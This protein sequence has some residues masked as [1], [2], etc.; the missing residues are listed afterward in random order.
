MQND[1]GQEALQNDQG[2]E[3]LQSGQKELGSCKTSDA[4]ASHKKATAK[5][6]EEDLLLAEVQEA[7]THKMSTV[8]T[9]QMVVL[10]VDNM[11]SL[12]KGT[13]GNSVLADLLELTEVGGR[14]L[15]LLL[16][17]AVDF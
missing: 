6:A 13:V 16:S 17:A 15:S 5:K 2:Q 3:A 9:G 1:Q 14:N 12:A 4:K 10:L 8:T 7:L 11:N